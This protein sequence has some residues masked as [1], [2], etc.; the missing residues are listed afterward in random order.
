MGV[1]AYDGALGMARFFRDVCAY[2]KNWEEPV[3]EPQARRKLATL[4]KRLSKSLFHDL[5]EMGLIEFYSPHSRRVNK[6]VRVK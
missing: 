5:H 1:F 4:N 2:I 6:V 3:D